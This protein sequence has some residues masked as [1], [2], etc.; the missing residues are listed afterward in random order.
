MK[1]DAGALV[2]SPSD[3][4]NFLSCRHRAGLDLAVAHKQLTRPASTNPYAAILR[5]HGEDHEQEYVDS[6]LANGLTVVNARPSKETRA[7]ESTRLTLDAM[8]TGVDVIFQARL[9]GDS[10]AGYADILRR[11]EKPSAL[12]AWSYEAHDTKLARE[13]K[14][15]TILQLSAYSDMLGGMQGNTSSNQMQGLMQFGQMQQPQQGTHEHF[16][17]SHDGVNPSN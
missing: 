15:G 4:S 16:S 8:A 3:L 2:I 9:H 13:T 12:G 6:L 10:I 5:K 11:V 1:L 7:D 14:G 17:H